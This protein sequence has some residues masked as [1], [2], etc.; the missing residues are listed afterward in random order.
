ML[1]LRR[2]TP[3]EQ[4]RSWAIPCI[5]NGI[6]PNQVQQ[7]AAPAPGE[8]VECRGCQHLGMGWVHQPGVR[9]VFRFRCGKQHALLELGFFGERVLIA[10]PECGDYAGKS[11]SVLASGAYQGGGKDLGYCPSLEH[12]HE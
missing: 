12:H 2:C 9:R 6:D 1:S 8:G 7:P 3:A 11:S 4:V 5:E 10:P